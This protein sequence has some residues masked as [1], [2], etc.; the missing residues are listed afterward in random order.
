M[1]IKNDLLNKGVGFIEPESIH[2]ADD[3][4]PDFISSDVT[5][6]PGTRISGAETSIGPGSHIGTEAPASIVNCQLGARVCLGGGYFKGT[7]FLNDTSMGS[8]SHLRPGTI[9]EEYAGGAHTVGFKHTIL[10]PYVKAGSLINFCDV[11]LAGGT[12]KRNHSEIGSSYVH[13]NFTP[14]KDKATASLLGDVPG[15][16]MLN[17]DPIFLGGQGGLV[18]PA[19]IAYGTVLV[20]GSICRK[21]I[22]EEG[23]LCQGG[24]SSGGSIPYQQHLI[25]SVKRIFKHNVNYIGNLYALHHWY[26]HV[27][28]LF[29][30]DQPDQMRCWSGAIRTIEAGIAERVHRLE[31]WITGIDVQHRECTNMVNKTLSDE[32]RQAQCALLNAW[33]EIQTVLRTDCDVHEGRDVFVKCLSKN[34]DYLTTIHALN[35]D[36]RR[37]GTTWLQAIVDEYMKLE[38]VM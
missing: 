34:Q 18:G 17:R 37:M 3:V 23:M 9:L 21:D 38:H 13:F 6:Y 27:R 24:S 20:A 12:D 5:F 1:T 36:Q 7:V 26:M 16:V 11:L 8:G 4:N 10:F 35:D 32:E 19:R 25:K 2:I 33:P 29:M 15:G 22:L 28:R 30:E 14:H 31:E